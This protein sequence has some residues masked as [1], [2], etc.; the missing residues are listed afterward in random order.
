MKKFVG[1]GLIVALS[2]ALFSCGTSKAKAQEHPFKVLQATFV[3][4]GGEQ[5]NLVKTTIKISIDNKEIKLDSVYFR[6]HKAPLKHVDSTENFIFAGSFTTS[7]TPHDYI[8]HSDPKQEFGNKPSVTIL[9]LP[10]ELADNE[11]V[12]SYFYKDKI[13]YYKIS[14]V[15][16]E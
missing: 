9:N 3:N 4:S 13:N 5:P 16:Q 8:L 6:N 15:K 1:I 12:V 7:T 11:V 14:E 10:F 2:I